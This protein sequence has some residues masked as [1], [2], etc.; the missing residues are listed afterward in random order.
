MAE[1]ASWAIQV[2]LNI[3]ALEWRVRDAL[4]VAPPEVAECAI[5]RMTL[6]GGLVELAAELLSEQVGPSLASQMLA[7]LAPREQGR[8]SSRRIGAPAA[9]CSFLARQHGLEN[10]HGHRAAGT[11]GA[12][13]AVLR[14]RHHGW[15]CHCRAD[16]PPDQARR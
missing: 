16:P 6:A 14:R 10:E 15:P 4:D 8:S 7:D 1:L 12:A 13:A 11:T 2:W 5:G 9:A 3:G